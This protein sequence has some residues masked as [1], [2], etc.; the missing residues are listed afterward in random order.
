M[1]NLPSAP[2][3]QSNPPIRPP[4][5]IVMDMNSCRLTTANQ[6]QKFKTEAFM[7]EFESCKDMSN[8]DL[9]ECFKTF[10][11]I[12]VGQGQIRLNL[13]K[14]NKIKAFT[15]WV[16]YQYRLG[17]D[18]TGL[19]LPD[20]HAEELLRRAKTHHLFV[21]KSDTISKAAKPLRLTNQVK[22]KDWAVS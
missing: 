21:S 8:E 19:P 9:A 13:Q 17:I 22:W 2:H 5:I 10:S 11:G 6:Y 1:A 7:D 3:N 12:T 4:Y 16:K 14:K 15:H 20:T 18:P